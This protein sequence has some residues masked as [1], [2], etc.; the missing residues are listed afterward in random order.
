[1]TD[2]ERKKKYE[3]ER[4]PGLAT[5]LENLRSRIY[6]IL[7][8]IVKDNNP[9][10]GYTFNNYRLWNNYAILTFI[11]SNDEIHEDCVRI[12]LA[13]GKVENFGLEVF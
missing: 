13:T 9:K 6:C 8:G 5:E 11:D 10:K 2:N 3:R 7:D 12:N 4:L 1:M